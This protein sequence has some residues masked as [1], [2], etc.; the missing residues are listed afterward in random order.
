M[1]IDFSSGKIVVTSQEIQI[2]IDGDSQIV[3]RA[4]ADAIALLGGGANVVVA[5][6]S[7]VQW[8]VR[9]DD[10]QQLEEISSCLGV[11]IN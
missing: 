6:D 7:E 10:V 11:K 5:N 3:L 9:L 2:R 1:R 8:S 4:R